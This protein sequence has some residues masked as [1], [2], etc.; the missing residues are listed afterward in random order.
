MVSHG[1]GDQMKRLALALMIS[2]RPEG[3]VGSPHTVHRCPG[4]PVLSSQV[5]ECQKTKS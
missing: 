4:D 1:K 2:Q 3:A 5:R